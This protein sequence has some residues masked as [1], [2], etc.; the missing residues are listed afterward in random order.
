MK[1]PRDYTAPARGVRYLPR[2]LR[3]AAIVALSVL[4]IL[5]ASSSMATPSALAARPPEPSD[6]P[7]SV[8]L[9]T[10]GGRSALVS[11]DGDIAITIFPTMPANVRFTLLSNLPVN[12]IPA[13]PGIRVGGLV[14]NIAAGPCN[15]GGFVTLPAEI[16]LGIRYTDLEATAYNERAFFIARL[17]PDDNLWTDAMKLADDPG[18]NYV[19]ATIKHAGLYTVYFDVP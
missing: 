3:V 8:S 19:S 2:V 14:F 13:P 11:A 18:A 16:N 15:G 10:N 5:A 17:D 12:T 7:Q 9:C 1:Y 4:S 6:D